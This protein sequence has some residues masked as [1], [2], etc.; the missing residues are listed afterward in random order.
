MKRILFSTF[1]VL[2]IGLATAPA[3]HA[4]INCPLHLNDC[5]CVDGSTAGY[6][7]EICILG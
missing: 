6:P 3:A 7:H 1:A 4:Q 5:F 2:A